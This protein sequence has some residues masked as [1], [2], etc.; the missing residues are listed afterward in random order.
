MRHIFSFV[1]NADYFYQS[2]SFSLLFS[3]CRVDNKKR[4]KTV[5]IIKLILNIHINKSEE[6]RVREPPAFL[7]WKEVVTICAPFICH[8]SE[9]ENWNQERQRNCVVCR[10]NG[11]MYLK[12]FIFS[13]RYEEVWTDLKYSFFHTSVLV[14]FRFF[15]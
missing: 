1:L 5:K 6:K 2:V 13:Y 12:S 15:Q 9:N 8:I 4:R 14:V 3:W 10:V 11:W 7:S